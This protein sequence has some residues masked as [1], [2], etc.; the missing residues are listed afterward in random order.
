[1]KGSWRTEVGPLAV[2]AGMWAASLASWSRA[3]E[4]L[5]VHWG[6]YGEVDRWGGRAEALLL[7]PLMVFP[8]YL[9]LTFLPRLDPGRAN[10]DRFAGPYRLLRLAILLFMAVL[11][12]QTLAPIYGIRSNTGRIV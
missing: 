5:P 7:M 4:R 6:L 12:L 1:M 8:L 9:L 11:H 2:I 3:P 10:Y